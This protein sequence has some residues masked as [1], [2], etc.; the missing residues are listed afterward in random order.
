MFVSVLFLNTGGMLR[1]IVMDSKA[2]LTVEIIAKIVEGR[3]TI[4]NGAKL[5][6]K[7]QRIAYICLSKMNA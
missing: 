1:M 2:Q 5:L 7:C 3:I 4:A 6:S